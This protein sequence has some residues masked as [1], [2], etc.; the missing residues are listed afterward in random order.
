MTTGG[1]K[2]EEVGVLGGMPPAAPELTP[3]CRLG[4]WTAGGGG[5]DNLE[6]ASQS[7]SHQVEA[8]LLKDMW[9]CQ[10]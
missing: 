2:E 3:L 7:S 1:G 4:R 5:D 9:I 6:E 10:E 8:T